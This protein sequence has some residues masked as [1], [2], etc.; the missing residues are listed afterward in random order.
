MI[1]AL[2]AALS[3]PGVWLTW[4]L[5]RPV[6]GARKLGAY[7]DDPDVVSFGYVDSTGFF[8]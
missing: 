7:A 1:P 6:A 4:W 8:D 3:V 2:I 5:L